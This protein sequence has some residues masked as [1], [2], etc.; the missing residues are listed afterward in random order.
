MPAAFVFTTF[1]FGGHVTPALATASRLAA[2]GHRVLIVS[3]EATRGEA[4]SF[5]LSFP[6]LEHRPPTGPTRRSPT[7]RCATGKRRPPQT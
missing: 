1:E 2:R 6:E 3:D 5:G 4:Q 7:S